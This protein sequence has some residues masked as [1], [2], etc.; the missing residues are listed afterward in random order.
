[1]PVRD[2]Y[3]LKKVLIAYFFQCALAMPRVYSRRNSMQPMQ[4][5]DSG[6][7]YVRSDG[8]NG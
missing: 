7:S 1:M 6:G 5:K 2:K 4:R 3:L 8:V